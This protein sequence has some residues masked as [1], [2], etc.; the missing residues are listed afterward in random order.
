MVAALA[1]ALDNSSV[2]GGSFGKAREAVF[3]ACMAK[4]GWRKG[5]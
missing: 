5:G 4:A 3:N 1:G 2:R